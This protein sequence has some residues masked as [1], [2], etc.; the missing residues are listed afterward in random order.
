MAH[1]R[2]QVGDLLQS[3]G[4]LPI[5]METFRYFKKQN[6]HTNLISDLSLVKPGKSVILS[7]NGPCK[8]PGSHTSF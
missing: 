1:E 5:R 2:T 7:L 8:T 4:Y 6:C 3:H